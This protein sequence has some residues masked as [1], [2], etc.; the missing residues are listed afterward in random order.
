MPRPRLVDW[1]QEGLHR[2]LTFISTP[3]GFGKTTLLSEWVGGCGRPVA[4]LSLDEGANDPA[5]FLAYLVGALQT[6]EGSVGQGVLPAIQSPGAVNVELVLT[7]LINE[8]NRPAPF[9]NLCVRDA[10]IEDLTA[11]TSI[12][13]SLA[14]HHDRLRDAQL[15]TFRYLVL[16]QADIIIGFAC[17]VFA[18]PAAWSDAHDTSHL[19]QI[20]DVQITP[21]L[22]GRGYGTFLISSL[23]QLAAHRG[24]EEIFLA[25]DPRNNPRAFALYQRLG[26]QPLQAEP[27]LKNWEFVDSGGRFHSG[28]DWIVDM[29]KPL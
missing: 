20:V 27:Y 23:E 7:T 25:V 5:R 21:A 4:W 12:K 9:N 1:L 24:F 2:K 6:I 17:L 18:R 10:T 11:L 19:P 28:D 13:D 29:A 16:E 14:L 8:M 3:A 15:P 26:Y 22:R